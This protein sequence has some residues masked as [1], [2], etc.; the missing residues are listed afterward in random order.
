MQNQ[1]QVKLIKKWLEEEIADCYANFELVLD[2][3]ELDNS[4]ISER[5]FKKKK[6]LKAWHMMA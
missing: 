2:R 3:F 6:H 1:L 5:I 4:A